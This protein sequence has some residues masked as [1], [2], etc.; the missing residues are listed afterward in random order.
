MTTFFEKNVVIKRIV[1]AVCAYL[2]VLS[3]SKIFS[4]NSDLSNYF[5]GLY[6][7]YN[8]GS[9]IVFLGC[10]YILCRLLTNAD[11][12]LKIVSVVGGILLSA[13]CVYGAYAHYMN[14]IFI[15]AKE[16]VLQFFLIL[17]IAFLTIPLSA[18]IIQLFDKGTK[19]LAAKKD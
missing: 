6:W 3:I 2:A 18:E 12:R 17:G 4:L 19:W 10:A 11:K 13:C 14:D 16:G 9:V 8:V 15:S 5:T 1:S 7:G